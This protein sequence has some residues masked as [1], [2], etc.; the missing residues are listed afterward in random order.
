M[1]LE[2]K[3]TQEL[4]GEGAFQHIQ[5]ISEEIPTRMAGTEEC[6]QMAEY[7]RD[8]MIHHGIPT[9]IKEFDARVGFT[10]TS[11]LMILD[12]ERRVI[13]CRP[14]VH[15]ANTTPAGIESELIFVGSGGVDDY[16]GKEVQGKITLSELSYSPPRQ[17]KQRIA[18]E[19]GSVAQIMI[20][21]GPS[22]SKTLAYGSVKPPWGN[23]TPIT[24]PGM[25][26]IPSITISRADGEHLIDL[27][28]KGRVRVWLRAESPEEWRQAQNTIGF[29]EGNEEPERFVI[30]GGHMDSWGGGVTC[31]ATGNFAVLEITRALA[32]HRHELKRSIRICFW[33]GHET[34]TMVGSSW[35]VDHS[36]DDL[37]QNGIAY[38]NVDSPGMRGTSYYS[39]SSSTE[40]A[41]FHLAVEQEILGEKTRHKRL[42]HT[43]DQSFMGIGI[44]S[45]SGRT[46]YTAEQIKVW[47]GAN[48]A[49]WHHS[50][51]MTL[52][53]MDVSL[54]LKAMKVYVAY[55]V[56]LGNT[57]ILPFDHQTM[58][59]EL[60]DRL[61]AIASAVGGRLGLSKPRKWAEQ[62][63]RNTKA[64]DEHLQVLRKE[65]QGA[66]SWKGNQKVMLANRI[67]MKLSR[68][69]HPINYSIA[70]RY[71]FDHY[72]LTALSTPIPCLYDS[73][74]LTTL[75]PQSND[76]RALLT[77]LVQQTNRVSDG[78]REAS[79][80]IEMTLDSL[81]RA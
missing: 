14:F 51:E 79:E 77:H 43:G 1:E 5:K 10:G 28:R 3:I 60:K 33:S 64:L 4:S 19:H 18:A 37:D 58:A 74:Y 66:T 80:L 65:T 46:E 55:I 57:A 20:N 81:Q 54:M 75:S 42:A 36:W 7:L 8:Q 27:Y 49:P 59:Q 24:L 56:R 11:E 32:Q 44:P 70:N 38:I 23:P 69:L 63:V 52:D 53:K 15:I 71:G 26:R 25:P 31:N 22:D 17:E 61:E 21:W 67:Q 2:E 41:Q 35:F 50:D 78:L 72:G 47:H 29:L 9:A 62:L 68:I 34:G 30:F 12:Q 76:Y 6:R 39:A 13:P 48:L 73:R 40:L 16:P 45:I